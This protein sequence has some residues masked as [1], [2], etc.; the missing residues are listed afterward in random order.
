[1][2]LFQYLY[3]NLLE[4]TNNI[5]CELAGGVDRWEEIFFYL[6]ASSTAYY[7][8]TGSFSQ[9]KAGRS[10]FNDETFIL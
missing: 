6:P 1:M 9:S 7:L 10:S 2:L 3:L 8:N 5:T 4:Q